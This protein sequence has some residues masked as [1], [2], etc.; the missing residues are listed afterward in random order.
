M[1]LKQSFVQMLKEAFGFDH[2]DIYQILRDRDPWRIRRTTYL[3]NCSGEK[4]QKSELEFQKEMNLAYRTARIVRLQNK[5]FPQRQTLFLPVSENKQITHLIRAERSNAD[6]TTD[7]PFKKNLLNSIRLFS[8]YLFLLNS[9]T[10]DP[11]TNLY[12]RLAYNSFIIQVFEKGNDLP[13]ALDPL[14]YSALAIM[15]IDNFKNINDTHGHIIGDEVLVSIGQMMLA[16]FRPRDQLFRYGGEEFICA[17]H[18]TNHEQALQILDRFRKNIEDFVFP[19]VSHVTKLS[20]IP[21]E[22]DFS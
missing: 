6:N 15:D 1:L 18:S 3:L 16:S 7:I 19:V 17:L 2:V 11:L 22:F 21:L 5:K 10:K 4:Q 13:K 14:E 8:H 9:K 20:L 12:N